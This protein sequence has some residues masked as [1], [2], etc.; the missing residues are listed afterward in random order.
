[1]LPVF[2]FS[3]FLNAQKVRTTMAELWGSSHLSLG[4]QKK[5]KRIC[6]VSS[7]PINSPPPPALSAGQKTYEVV[8]AGVQSIGSTHFWVGLPRQ[9]HHCIWLYS[10]CGIEGWE[11]ET[12]GAQGC[13]PVRL[14][15]YWVEHLSHQMQVEGWRSLISCWRQEWT[16]KH[17][18]PQLKPQRLWG[19]I[20]DAEG[21][22]WWDSRK[23]WTFGLNHTQGTIKCILSL[24]NN[25]NNNNKL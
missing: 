16:R 8:S 5:K 14:M 7:F 6:P 1:M 9:H 22:V 15:H 19:L 2:S 11:R 13:W 24:G 17:S 4:T 23:T 10:V 18:W 21:L 20:Q 25:N 12:Q 3:L